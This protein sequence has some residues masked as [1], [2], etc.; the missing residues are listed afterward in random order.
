MT[1]KKQ[2]LVGIVVLW[3]VAWPAWAQPQTDSLFPFPSAI[4][5][6]K[7]STKVIVQ[8]C[9]NEASARFT[10]LEQLMMARSTANHD[11]AYANVIRWGNII[12]EQT[13]AIREMRKL[14]E[15]SIPATVA[16]D[17]QSWCTA[18]EVCWTSLDEL[19]VP[20]TGKEEAALEI[21][22]MERANRHA[23]AILDKYRVEYEKLNDIYHQ[24]ET[25]LIWITL[26]RARQH[27]PVVNSAI[28]RSASAAYCVDRHQQEISEFIQRRNRTVQQWKQALDNF[29]KWQISS[30]YFPA[31]EPKR[32]QWKA[33]VREMMEQAHRSWQEWVDTVIPIQQDKLL[34]NHHYIKDLK[35]ADLPTKFRAFSQRLSEKIREMERGK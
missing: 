17:L 15:Q 3:T 21:H 6:A 19:V 2:W 7:S 12:H 33:H 9:L 24:T 22:D 34:A 29:D 14:L 11:A 35:P 5:K 26:E 32:N 28:A 16:T 20:F 8:G 1:N 25:A 27:L 18:L 23:R 4:A 13:A 30:Q 10:D 31:L